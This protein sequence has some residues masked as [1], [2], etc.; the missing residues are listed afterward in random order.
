MTTM[1][2]YE[3]QRAVVIR[4]GWKA[5]SGLKEKRALKE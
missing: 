3:A 5:T 4:N 1:Y 2:V